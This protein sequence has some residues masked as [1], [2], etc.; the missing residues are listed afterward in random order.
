MQATTTD[1]SGPNES[2]FNEDC[3]DDPNDD[4]AQVHPQVTLSKSRLPME[5]LGSSCSTST[6]YALQ[7]LNC[8]QIEAAIELCDG[9]DNDCSL[10]IYNPTAFDGIPDDEKDDDSD[11]HV[12]CA[13]DAGSW[14]GLITTNFTQ[15]LGEDCDD[16][17]E[18]I[19]PLALELCDVARQ[20]L[21]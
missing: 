1:C 2:P 16:A 14:D 18:T 12:E 11:G 10:D 7:P 4:G 20:Q 19:Y 6:P 15:M 8:I 13:I 5:S 3:N 17:D 21:R 9:R